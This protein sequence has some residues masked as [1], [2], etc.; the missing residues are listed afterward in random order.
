[1][2]VLIKAAFFDAFGFTIDQWK[3]LR[4]ALLEHAAIHE[5]AH[6]LE[7]AHGVK[8]IIDGE[9]QAPDGRSPQVRAVWIIEADKDSPRLVTAYALKGERS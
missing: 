2:Y 4:D 8:Y 1:M 3:S 7:T 6:T 9:L 5:V